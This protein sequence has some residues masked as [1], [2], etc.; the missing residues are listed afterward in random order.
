M[1]PVSTVLTGLA[2]AR[3]AI[4]FVKENLDSLDDAAEIAGRVGQ[5]LEGHHQYNKKRFTPSLRDSLQDAV[6]WKLQQE[7]LYNLSVALDLRLGNGFYANVVQQHQE[8]LK[9]LVEEERIARI[10]RRKKVEQA[11]IGGALIGALGLAGFLIFI[12]IMAVRN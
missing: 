10:K 12:I 2:L 1:E 6:E 4:S 8:K 3:Q 11:M 7:E 9:R 5:I